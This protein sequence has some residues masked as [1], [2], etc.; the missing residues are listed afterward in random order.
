M[1]PLAMLRSPINFNP[2]NKELTPVNDLRKTLEANKFLVGDKISCRSSQNADFY[3][4]LGN[5][6]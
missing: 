1:T 6:G 3:Q 2:Y 4:M 5:R